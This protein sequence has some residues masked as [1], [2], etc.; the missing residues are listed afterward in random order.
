[1]LE[2]SDL[3]EVVAVVS[4]Y[5]GGIKLGTGGLVRAYGGAVRQ[6]LAGM[7]TAECALHRMAR[8]TVGYGLYGSLQHVLARHGV[9]VEEA[10]F[11]EEVAML[12]AVPC[13]SARQVTGLLRDLSRGQIA[14][15]RNWLEDRYYV[16][17][18]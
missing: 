17:H 2:G 10:T 13:E 7:A 1:V 4:R 8:V 14:L 12:L 15:D 6:A 5:F 11:A 18:A 3:R 16:T 9:I